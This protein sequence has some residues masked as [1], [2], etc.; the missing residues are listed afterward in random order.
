[1]FR[2]LSDSLNTFCCVSS[3]PLIRCATRDQVV[4]HP[5]SSKT[6][7]PWT[8]IG[9]FW[10]LRIGTSWFLQMRTS[11]LPTILSYHQILGNNWRIAWAFGWTPRSRIRVCQVGYWSLQ[12][13]L[14]YVI[15]NKCLASRLLS[16]LEMSMHLVLCHF[17][18]VD[19]D[20]SFKSGRSWLAMERSDTS[21]T[22]ACSSLLTSSD[23]EEYDEHDMWNPMLGL[24]AD[25]FM[26]AFFWIRVG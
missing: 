19:T 13:K 14:C 2:L 21:S 11:T 24:R 10:K 16:L 1:M 8:R 18:P 6:W 12:P 20:V 7:V 3:Q 15:A 26:E 22:C 9:T 25:E 17:G 4:Q 23:P 5:S